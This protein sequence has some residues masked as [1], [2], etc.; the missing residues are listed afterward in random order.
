MIGMTLKSYWKVA[1]SIL[2]ETQMIYFCKWVL[3]E[4]DL[5]SEFYANVE[6]MELCILDGMRDKSL[7]DKV[8]S[9]LPKFKARVL[10][11][12]NEV[13]KVLESGM[14]GDKRTEALVTQR[15]KL[16]AQVKTLL[17]QTPQA[18]TGI[19]SSAKAIN[20]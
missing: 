6:G 9:L 19:C 12:R 1:R 4:T 14:Q 8:K 11:C 15:E 20:A 7:P 2:W 5:A 17:D 13:Q 18:V 3:G 10:Q 16:F